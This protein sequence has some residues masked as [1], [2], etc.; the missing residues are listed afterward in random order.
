VWDQPNSAIKVRQAL[1]TS[2][3]RAAQATLRCTKN[4]SARA[5][6]ALLC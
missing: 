4:K 5:S 3:V 6:L 2:I 1:G